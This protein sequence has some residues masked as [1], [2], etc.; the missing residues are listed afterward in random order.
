VGAGLA[1]TRLYPEFR[2]LR[3]RAGSPRV[4]AHTTARP[5]ADSTPSALTL[6]AQVYFARIVGGK[7]RLAP[8]DREVSAESPAQGALDELISGDLPA[9][10]T[11][12]LPE[13]TQLRHLRVEGGIAIADFSRELVSNFQ[14]GS[15]SEGVI[16]YAIVNTLTSLPGVKQAQ[17]LVDGK[18][19]DSIGGHLDT[20]GPL[21]A[22]GELVVR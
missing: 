18:P 7:E 19:L 6:T 22:D 3:T 11:H 8:V 17:I 21:A 20:S 16:V 2:K 5:R 4:P 12:P 1:F 13:G 10:C 9:G 14:G 15:D